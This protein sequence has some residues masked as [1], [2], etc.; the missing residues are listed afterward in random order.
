MLSISRRQSLGSRRGN[1]WRGEESSVLECLSEGAL[2]HPSCLPSKHFWYTG[3]TFFKWGTPRGG[4]DGKS[5]AGH[6]KAGSQWRNT[7]HHPSLPLP[8][9]QTPAA[10]LQT[11]WDTPICHGT[12]VAGGILFPGGIWLFTIGTRMP[13]KSKWSPFDQI[14]QVLLWFA[15]LSLKDPK[16][17]G[18]QEVLGFWQAARF[19][20]QTVLTHKMLAVQ[21]YAASCHTWEDAPF[22][23]HTA[24]CSPAHP[25][26]TVCCTH[27][28]PHC[29]LP[30]EVARWNNGHFPHSCLDPCLLPRGHQEQGTPEEPGWCRGITRICLTQCKSS[31]MVPGWSSSSTRS[32]R[33]NCNLIHM[34]ST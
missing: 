23:S 12:V 4:S 26:H 19:P 31:M 17:W 13:D 24:G 28:S 25:W 3:S 15:S 2:G 29:F 10:H 30:T 6:S 22:G 9:P 7:T 16:C 27:L 14:L 1:V 33:I 8:S 32:Y 21:K 5:E 18:K 34:A 20:L 11:I